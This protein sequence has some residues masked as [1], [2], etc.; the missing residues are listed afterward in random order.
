MQFLFFE[1]I[2]LILIFLFSDLINLRIGLLNKAVQGIVLLH[3]LYNPTISFIENQSCT[4]RS[5]FETSPLNIVSEL[6]M[7]KLSSNGVVVLG[8]ICGEVSNFVHLNIQLH[9]LETVL[10]FLEEVL[11]YIALQLTFHLVSLAKLRKT[12]IVV[13]KDVV[14]NIIYHIYNFHSP[15]I[16][17]CILAVHMTNI[18][19]ISTDFLYQT[20]VK[21]FVLFLQLM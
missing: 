8:Q 1:A 12:F 16:S 3:V 5:Y 2:Y 13:S 18:S 6:T 7:I 19:N 20:K 15:I 14:G 11:G 17:K 21:L 4:V 10:N 9:I